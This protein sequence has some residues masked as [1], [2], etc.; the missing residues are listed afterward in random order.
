MTSIDFANPT[1]LQIVT[2]IKSIQKRMKDPDL[3]NAEYIYV[4]DKL[5]KEFPYLFDN[6]TAIFTKVIRGEDLYVVAANLYYKDKIDRGLFTEAELRELLA[7]KY[8]GDDLSK[9]AAE[10][11]ERLKSEGKL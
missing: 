5:G 10:E 8:L 9:K 1:L 7:K 6:H 11:V 4:Y 3:V 2:T